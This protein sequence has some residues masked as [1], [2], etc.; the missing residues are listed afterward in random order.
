MQVRQMSAPLGAIIEDI[1]VRSVDAA[2]VAE[3]NMLFCQHHVLVFPKQQ[4]TPDEQVTFAQHWGELVPFPYGSLPGQPNIIELRNKGKK[5][6]VNQ[7]WHSDMTYDPNPPK[8]TMLYALQ[9]PA[10]GGE[11][12]FA[13]QIYAYEELSDG[14]KALVD[15]LTA[16]HSA[17][18]LARLY[19]QDPDQASEAEHPVVRTHDETGARALYVCQA[20]TREFKNWSRQES[21]VLLDYLY[22]H[23]VRPEYQ[24]RHQW[25]TGDLVMWDNRCLLHYAV[26]DHGD[27]PRLIHRLQVRGGAP[28]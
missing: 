7:H 6:D 23:C 4:L 9:A 19:G 1:D 17:K 22:E 24:A 10:L 28:H 25:Q 8:L 5:R 26:H 27:N 20:F 14:M 18:D 3:L 2:D 16:K 13:N 15:S 12:A 11:T 21:K